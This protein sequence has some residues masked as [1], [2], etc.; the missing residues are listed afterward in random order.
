MGTKYAWVR[1][2]HL[3][4]RVAQPICVLYLRSKTQEVM[5]RFTPVEMIV[6]L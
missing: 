3:V 1:R 6:R 5:V 2:T 4:T